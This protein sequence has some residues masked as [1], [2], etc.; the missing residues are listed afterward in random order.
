MCDSSS[1]F[2]IFDSDTDAVYAQVVVFSL[3]QGHSL[4]NNLIF[5]RLLEPRQSALLSK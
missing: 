5:S 4:Y 2:S 3:R 1:T